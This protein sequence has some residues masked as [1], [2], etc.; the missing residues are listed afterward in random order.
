MHLI[1][2]ETIY[3]ILFGSHAS[4]GVHRR[5]QRRKKASFTYTLLRSLARGVLRVEKGAMLC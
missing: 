5:V 2:K 3:S 4:E 1:M